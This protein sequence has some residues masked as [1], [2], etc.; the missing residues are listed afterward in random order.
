[1]PCQPAV[2]VRS[3]GQPQSLATTGCANLPGR[4]PCCTGRPVTNRCLGRPCA[5]LAAGLRVPA[6]PPASARHRR[7]SF[8]LQWCRSLSM[9]M[10][11]HQ[12]K[13]PSMPVQR[14]GPRLGTRLACV[15]DRD[16]ISQWPGPVSTGCRGS[17]REDPEL[18]FPIAHERPLRGTTDQR[19]E[20]RLPMLHV[21]P[22]CLSFGLQ[23][24]Q[25]GVWGGT[26]RE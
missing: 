7:T 4:S 21:R 5:A 19:S 26:I 3:A 10:T 25:D 8:H 1:M 22:T 24:R 12:A 20:R 18:F 6:Q 23:A 16:D 15:T 11:R 9:R 2:P 17:Q 14:S 13:L